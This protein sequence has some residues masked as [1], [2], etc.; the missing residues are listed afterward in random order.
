MNVRNAEGATPLIL[1]VTIGENSV[2]AILLR[3]GADFH[4]PD[5]NG[6]TALKRASGKGHLEIV[7][8]LL[9]KGAEINTRSR[10]DNVNALN[11]AVICEQIC[12]VGLLLNRGADVNAYCYGGSN[13][14]TAVDIGYLEV[15]ELLLLHGAGINAFVPS[16][17]GTALDIAITREQSEVEYSATIDLLRSKGG[18]KWEKLCDARFLES[19][20]GLDI[21]F[22]EPTE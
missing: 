18:K 2:V 4:I 5:S 22:E 3:S 6:N 16:K 19:L 9:E 12:V 7:E 8:L 14:A 10:W 11:W 1:A 15:V 13:L 21:L 17:N 20:E